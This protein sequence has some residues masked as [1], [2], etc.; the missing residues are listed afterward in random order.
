MLRSGWTH[1]P[2]S[3][4]P[5]NRRIGR[6]MSYEAGTFRPRTVKHYHHSC[7]SQTTSVAVSLWWWRAGWLVGVLKGQ[8]SKD[9]KRPIPLKGFCEHLNHEMAVL[10]Y[11]ASQWA[12]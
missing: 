8:G 9:T 10:L 3:A 11:I 12:G 4:K 5:S 7:C 1:S 2:V 6:D